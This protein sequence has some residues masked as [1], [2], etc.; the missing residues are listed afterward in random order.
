MVLHR[1]T[2]S[3]YERDII[4]VYELHR[5][6]KISRGIPS[7]G[8]L[9]TCDGKNLRFTTEIAV[10]LENGT[11]Q[12]HDYY[13]SLTL[14]TGSHRL[15]IDPYQLQADARGQTFLENLRNYVP[16]VRPRMTKF[17]TVTQVG[18]ACF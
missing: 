17:G 4:L 10:Y 16:M 8:A 1:E 3:P 13:G 7:A 2:F 6:Y 9:N 12:A 5:R 18:K 15:P 14:L 11:R